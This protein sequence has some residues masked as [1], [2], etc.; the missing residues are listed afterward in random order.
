MRTVITAGI[1]AEMAEKLGDKYYVSLGEGVWTLA[2]S[3]TLAKN[4][5]YQIICSADDPK[6]K[7][8]VSEI[9]PFKPL[10]GKSALVGNDR[11]RSESK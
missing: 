4:P 6:W 2:D 10:L 7:E 1:I 3:E 5:E 8:K 9:I 11:V